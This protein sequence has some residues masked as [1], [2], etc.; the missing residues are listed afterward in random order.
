MS[1]S[2]F[3]V[4][5]LPSGSMLNRL[6]VRAPRAAAFVELQNLLAITP[7]NTVSISD[8]ARILAKYNLL[9]ADAEVELRSILT[10]AAKHAVADHQLN[11]IDEAGLKRLQEAFEFSDEQVRTIFIDAARDLYRQTLV[12]A[13]ADG[14]LTSEERARLDRI[15]VD[16]GLSHS[17]SKQVYEEEALRAIQLVFDHVVADQK[18]SPDEDQ[19]LSEMSSALGVTLS[20]EEGTA[21]ILERYRLFGRID[22]GILPD[23]PVQIPLQHGE[24]C[25]FT[26]DHVTQK[27]LRT[28][29]RTVAD[30]RPATRVPTMKGVRFRIGSI[31]SQRLTQDVLATIDQGPLYVTSKRVLIQG[32]HKKTSMPL[33]RLLHFTVFSDG[34]QI[35][36]DSGKDIFVTGE[37]DWEV[38]G[39]CLD[40]AAR[41]GR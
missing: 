34:M 7:W 40:V 31:S 13:L 6:A 24:S 16:L 15:A 21:R 32:A 9:P 2:P 27:E 33:S 14:H 23:V 41:A 4:E 25:H 5:Q 38:A 35:H 18:V 22:A 12:D 37:A 39:A 19:R 10:R 8:V 30:A 28:I 1:K 17:E 20:H 26:A 36:K 11:E 29:A 3:V